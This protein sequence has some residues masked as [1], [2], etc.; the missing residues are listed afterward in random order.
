MSGGE[1]D[2]VTMASMMR[3]FRGVDTIL[4]LCPGK[5]RAGSEHAMRSRGTPRAKSAQDMSP[6]IRRPIP[7]EVPL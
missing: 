4:D 5:C 7:D 3:A 1:S 2:V 6:C